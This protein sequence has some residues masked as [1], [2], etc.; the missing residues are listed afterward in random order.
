V[1]AA[2]KI[3]LA[4]AG[5]AALF[6]FLDWWKWVSY[7]AN[8]DFAIF[9]QSIASGFPAYH[10]MEEGGNH[11]GVHFSPIYALFQPL[12]D[13]FQTVLPLIVA[14]AV[15]GALTG[16]GVFFLARRLMP[17]RRAVGVACVAFVYPALAGLIF[18]DPF[19]TVF[20][21]AATVWLLY[22]FEAR[23]VTIIAVAALVALSIKEDQ[24]IFLTLTG[25]FLAWRHRHERQLLA[26]G[27]AVAAASVMTLALYFA[28]LQPLAGGTWTGTHFYDW[29]HASVD[30]APWYSPIRVMYLIQVFLPLLFVPFRS[31]FLWLAAVPFIELLASPYTILF[32]NGTHYAGVWIGYVLAA[33]AYG[34]AGVDPPVRAQRLLAASLILCVLQL[35]L[36]SPTHWRVRLHVPNAHDRTLG[37]VL[38][39]LPRTATIAT[40]EEAYSHLGFYPNAVEGLRGTPQF[41]VIDSTRPVSYFVP[42]LTRYVADHP[43]YKLVRAED[44]ID[45]Y[46]RSP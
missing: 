17:E 34:M 4:G 41:V 32:T 26:S 20:A 29:A 35:T 6:S 28:V 39:G 16:V 10:N 23:K 42:I 22:G 8:G 45:V 21:P 19:E 43:A 38:A 9:V 15:A 40:Y 5:W 14:P 12:M 24:A 2:R 33:Y 11:F 36:A 31:P 7:N 27:L 25:L 18:G 1:T 3:W 44:G 46:E 13:P 37:A 30:V